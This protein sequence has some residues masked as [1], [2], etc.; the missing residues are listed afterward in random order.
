MN[1]GYFSQEDRAWEGEEEYM[2]S[3]FQGVYQAHGEPHSRMVNGLHL[4]SAF[5]T[6]GHSDTLY[7]TASHSPIHAHI[8]T[9]AA[10]S[11][12]QGNSQLVMSSHGEASCSGTPLHSSRGAGDRTSNLLVTSQP[13]LPPQPHMNV[14]QPNKG[15]TEVCPGPG[16][17]PPPIPH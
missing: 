3:S 13:A 2:N 12:M 1:M 16:P 10:E 14:K 5:L 15:Q 17:P 9:P 11:S 7:N 8:H 6:S 4:F